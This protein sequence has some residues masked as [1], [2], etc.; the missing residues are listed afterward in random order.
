MLPGMLYI[1]CFPQVLFGRTRK[2]GGGY[3]W[4]LFYGVRCGLM[5]DC[6]FCSF[7]QPIT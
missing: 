6:P 1:Q 2:V 4:L 3:G 5:I 7:V